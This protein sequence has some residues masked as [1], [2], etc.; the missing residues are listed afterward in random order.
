MLI[1]IDAPGLGLGRPCKARGENTDRD[2]DHGPAGGSI[3]L[4]H[5]VAPESPGAAWVTRTPDPR[6]TNANLPGLHL[7]YQG[8]IL[9]PNQKKMT[10]FLGQAYVGHK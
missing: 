10:I 5:P 7:I 3:S 4:A 6:I 9:I 2:Q 1:G 8:V